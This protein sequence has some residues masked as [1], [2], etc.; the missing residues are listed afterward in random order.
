MTAKAQSMPNPNTKPPK[1]LLRNYL[2]DARFQLKY[3]GAVVLVTTLVAGGVGGWLGYEAYNYSRGMSDMLLMQQGG[4]MEDVDDELHALL[5]NEARERDVEVRNQIILGIVLLVVILALALGF[6]GIVVTHKVVGPAY[7]L[8]LQLG[9]VAGG[10][11]N[12]HGGF[13]KGD[14][15]QEVGEAFKAMVTA[16][17]ER[18]EAEIAELDRIREAAE[19]AQSADEGS[20]ADDADLVEQIDALRDRMHVPL[21]A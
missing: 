1:R 17:R 9:D 13:R 4:M 10:N 21:D 7:K 5:E 2:L 3:T 14:E 19:R 16:L 18:R 8:K 15:L 6:T 12:V 20:V 11:L